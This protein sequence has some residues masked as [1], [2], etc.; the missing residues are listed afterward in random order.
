MLATITAITAS[1]NISWPVV[2]F[3]PPSTTRGIW[4]LLTGL[5]WISSCYVQW[6]W[7][8]QSWGDVLRLLL[9]PKAGFAVVRA[10]GPSPEL[11]FLSTGQALC[12]VHSDLLFRS[13]MREIHCP[14]FSDEDTD[15]Q[16]GAWSPSTLVFKVGSGACARCCTGWWGWSGRMQS[17]PA[18]VHQ[19]GEG[20]LAKQTRHLGRKEEWTVKRIRYGGSPR[21]PWEAQA[22]HR[23]SDSWTQFWKK[24]HFLGGQSRELL[25]GKGISTRRMVS[26]EK[27]G[28]QAVWRRTARV[29]FHLTQQSAV[30][31]WWKAVRRLVCQSR[32]WG[33]VWWRM[34]SRARTFC[35]S[36]C[37]YNTALSFLSVRWV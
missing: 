9:D 8:L 11:P 27:R 15:A 5:D 2:G 13:S 35:Y 33:S 22:S 12:F 37:C 6:K 7:A 32:V 16:V 31:Q 34:G 29:N 18:H 4:V 23:G 28:H 20:G 24:Q 36:H 17:L 25:G 1:V 14:Q 3:P 19:R 10:D 26:A 30:G 21:G